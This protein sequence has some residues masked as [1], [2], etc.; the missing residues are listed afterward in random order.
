LQEVFKNFTVLDKMNSRTIKIKAVKGQ[1]HCFSMQVLISKC[2]L[3]PE[4][5]WHRFVFSCRFLEK[6]A[7]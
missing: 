6:R 5:K 7:L 2:F 3:Y 1:V 4:K